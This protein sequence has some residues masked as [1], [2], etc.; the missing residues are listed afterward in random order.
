MSK[1]R[2][3]LGKRRP[4]CFPTAPEYWVEFGS[5]GTNWPMLHHVGKTGLFLDEFLDVLENWAASRNFGDHVYIED[6]KS[7]DSIHYRISLGS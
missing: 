1:M 4:A 5:L 6:I 2:R 7:D 3:A